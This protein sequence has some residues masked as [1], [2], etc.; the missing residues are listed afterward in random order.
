VNV[1]MCYDSFDNSNDRIG[2]FKS[3]TI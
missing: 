1:K 3:A 2:V